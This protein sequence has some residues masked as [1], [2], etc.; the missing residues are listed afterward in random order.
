MKLLFLAVL[1]ERKK[2][3]ETVR[4]INKENNNFLSKFILLLVI[5]VEFF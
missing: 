4:T 3:E 1:S 2:D 5:F